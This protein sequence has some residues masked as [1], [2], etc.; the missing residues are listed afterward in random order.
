[1]VMGARGV[2]EI[3]VLVDLQTNEVV[4]IDPRDPGEII[5]GPELRQEAQDLRARMQ[6][7]FDPSEAYGD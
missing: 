2:Q 6:N 7:G 3:D 1:M 4:S 5:P